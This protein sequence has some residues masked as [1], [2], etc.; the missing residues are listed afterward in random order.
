MAYAKIQ[1]GL[2][3]EKEIRGKKILFVNFERLI[4]E[5]MIF[6]AEL[7]E[8]DQLALTISRVMKEAGDK[9]E[10]NIDEI[11]TNYSQRMNKL[12]YLY[13]KTNISKF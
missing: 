13:K 4:F 2:Q 11:K 6:S 3:R 8:F 7:D 5:T 1:V 10:N 9:V 12:E